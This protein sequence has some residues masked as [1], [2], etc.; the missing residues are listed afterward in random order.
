MKHYNSKGVDNM[1]KDNWT[2]NTNKVLAWL[3][4]ED[5]GASG[6]AIQLSITLGNN[7]TDD[8]G[9]SQYWTAIRSFGAGF[10]DFPAARKGQQSSLPTDIQVNVDSVTQM[11]KNVFAD[12]GEQDL[13]LTVILPHGR[14]GGA[15]ADI[16]AMA[17]YFSN[18]AGRNL[19]N[20]YKDGRW[21]GSMNGNIPTMTPPPVK[22]DE[23]G[24]EEE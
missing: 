22:A 5:R 21:D 14:T 19:V 1:K 9:R 10:E 3:E 4:K 15:Y 12:I 2:T 17:T 13:I 6:E 11:V 7:A 16:D 23:G 20:A 8:D 24:Q 18:Q